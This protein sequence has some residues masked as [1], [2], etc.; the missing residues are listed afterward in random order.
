MGFSECC[1]GS[2][3]FK[4]PYPEEL[5]CVFCRRKNE[6]WSDEPETL[7]KGC[8]KTISRDLKAGCLAW[9]PSAREC[10]G[11]DKYERLMKHLKDR[12]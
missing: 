10:L 3:E 2:R 7:C 8:G 5:I 4:A 6:I 11:A 1:P 12:S 9:C